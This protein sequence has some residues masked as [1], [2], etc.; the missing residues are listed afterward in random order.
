MAARGILRVDDAVKLTTFAVGR[1]KRSGLLDQQGGESDT[2]KCPPCG[3]LGEIAAGAPIYSLTMR[4]QPLGETTAG[5]RP[6]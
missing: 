6:A 2:K 1:L 3:G 5:A 4:N